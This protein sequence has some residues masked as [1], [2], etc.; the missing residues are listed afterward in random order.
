MWLQLIEVRA[1]KRS[2]G[3]WSC[4]YRK[5]KSQVAKREGHFSVSHQWGPIPGLFL[6]PG[7][8]RVHLRS[9][10]SNPSTVPNDSE[11]T[12]SWAPFPSVINFRNWIPSAGPCFSEASAGL[13]HPEQL[14]AVGVTS[15]SLLGLATSLCPSIQGSSPRGALVLWTSGEACR[16]FL[17]VLNTWKK[18]CKMNQLYWSTDISRCFCPIWDRVIYLNTLNSET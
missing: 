1:S 2:P 11:L 15:L 13:G 4:V 14:V 16:S 7:F 5:S 6:Q 10:F 17:M 18:S 8:G 3:P 9:M 12:S